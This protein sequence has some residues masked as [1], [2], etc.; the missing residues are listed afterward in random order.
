MKNIELRNKE[1][2]Y[3][4]KEFTD[5]FYRAFHQKF[6]TVGFS[7]LDTFTTVLYNFVKEYLNLEEDEYVPMIIVD[8]V[9]ILGSK[10]IYKYTL[11]LKRYDSTLNKVEEINFYPTEQVIVKSY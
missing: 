6:G 7:S 2:K 11:Q 4:T 1:T 9:V 3:A 10:K 8:D 5:K